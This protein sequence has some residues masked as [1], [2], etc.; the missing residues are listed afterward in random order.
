MFLASPQAF[1]SLF[2]LIFFLSIQRGR[3]WLISPHGINDEVG[4]F[5]NKCSLSW[6]PLATVLWLYTLSILYWM[7]P[8]ERWWS[9]SKILTRAL[10]RTTGMMTHCSEILPRFNA[11]RGLL[12]SEQKNTQHPLFLASCGMLPN[13]SFKS[14]PYKRQQ[15]MCLFP[16]RK[17]LSPFNTCQ[18]EYNQGKREMKRAPLSKTAEKRQILIFCLESQWKKRS[19]AING[20]RSIVQSK[21]F[22]FGSKAFE[23]DQKR[24]SLIKSVRLRLKAFSWKRSIDIGCPQNWQFLPLCKV[25]CNSVQKIRRKTAKYL[26]HTFMIDDQSE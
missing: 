9:S 24:S 21:V 22:E 4:N 1:L 16:S 2:F 18:I 8:T 17:C 13:A 26:S 14:V 7:Y 6:P 3:K 23:F 15:W 10:F 20:K 12:E 5:L 19:K 25:P 11:L